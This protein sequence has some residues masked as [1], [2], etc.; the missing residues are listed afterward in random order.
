MGDRPSK[1]P[2]RNASDSDG[3]SGSIS[4]RTLLRT[5]GAAGA[6]ALVP[7]ALTGE[8]RR[9][10]AQPVDP[11]TTPP[12]AA[13][14][15]ALGGG[16]TSS[17]PAGPLMNLTAR[18]SEILAAMV[19]RLVPSDDV[20]PGALEA[21]VLHF[22]DRALSEAASESAEAYRNGIAALDA[23][24][25][26]SRGA[27][28]LELTERDQD[29]VLLDLQ[30]G[31]ATGAGVGF[32]GSSASFFNMVK[33]HTWQGMFGDPQ[34]GGN[35]GFAGW[36]LLRYPGVR[37]RVTD[38]EQALLDRGELSDARRSAYDFGQ[39]QAGGGD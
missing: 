29:S 32:V 10:P 20:G 21:G 39:F 26:Y 36:D 22:I 3:E 23:Y 14:V 1:G 13:P 31:G 15:A 24:S 25:R 27:P 8:G 33:G 4:R 19:D 18:E 37:M 28:F 34:Y 2:E 17:A 30:T 7:S 11:S 6:A 16:A 35:V 5:A 38:D 12:P 9:S